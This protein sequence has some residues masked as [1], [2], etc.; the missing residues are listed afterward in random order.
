VTKSIRPDPVIYERGECGIRKTSV[1]RLGGEMT[2]GRHGK[3]RRFRSSRRSVPHVLQ[4]LL[5]GVD[6]TGR[7]K[8]CAIERAIE[9]LRYKIGLSAKRK[10][11]K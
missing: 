4:E 7:C 9:D 8:A 10:K 3:T 5:T 2:V 1:P 6:T 11:D